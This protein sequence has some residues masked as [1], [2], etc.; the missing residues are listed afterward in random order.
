[1]ITKESFLEKYNI[2]EDSLLSAEVSWEDLCD[3]YTDFGENKYDRYQSILDDFV[4]N[5]L[6]DIIRNKACGNEKVKIHSFRTRV[7][8]PEHLIA[9]II[10]RK[11][12]NQKKYKLL[13]KDNYEKFITDLIGIRCFVLFKEDWTSF[14]NYI[15]SKFD[16]NVEYYIRD[17][18]KDFDTDENHFY[19]AEKPKVHI[20]NG[21]ARE[22]YDKVLS[23]DCVIDGKVYRSVHYIIKYKGV[24][25]EIQV[26]TLFEEGW[27][28]VDHA[29]VYPYYKDDQI[30]KEYTALLNRLSGLADEMSSFFYRLKILETEN[31]KYADSS[32]GNG[33]Q[34]AE[35]SDGDN[36]KT[37]GSVQATSNPQKPMNT[38]NDCLRL[39]LDE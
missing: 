33:T 6:K 14:H 2:K 17:S 31:I 36:P 15:V 34:G 27:G 20:R 10:K 25:L 18:I 39:V 16:N 22:I 23:P 7:K 28:E 12:E 19:I 35:T 30:L 32:C 37:E 13:D 38:P 3:I 9:K 1:M 21:D 24:Y 26:R 5:Y 29:V 8:D 11:N 4:D